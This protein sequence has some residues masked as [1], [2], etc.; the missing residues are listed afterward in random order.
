MRTAVLFLSRSPGMRCFIDLVRHMTIKILCLAVMMLVPIFLN[1]GF[2]ADDDFREF[3]SLSEEQTYSGIFSSVITSRH[4]KPGGRIIG[5]VT[6]TQSLILSRNNNLAEEDQILAIA[7]MS[8]DIEDREPSDETF[9]IEYGAKTK[10]LS[11]IVGG[12]V[13]PYFND[14][15]SVGC[16]YWKLR[17]E[18]GSTPSHLIYGRWNHS[19]RADWAL[20]AMYGFP[21]DRRQSSGLL[22]FQMNDFWALPG[23]GD[24]TR[25]I[26]HVGVAYGVNW[27]DAV[28][29]GTV[30]TLGI[31]LKRR[32]NRYIRFGLNIEGQRRLNG[33][34]S[35]IYNKSWSG[36][37]MDILF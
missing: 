36:A 20:T 2:A 1:A 26:P 11:R 31:G 37:V 21:R 5:G 10:L 12:Y 13:R 6:T 18:A 33:N 9:G 29:D 34:K 16:R 23:M 15:L 14:R 24:A 32:I 30:I 17:K 8:T 27:F 7:M 35:A 4:L 19:S 3:H 28:H 25:L 22:E